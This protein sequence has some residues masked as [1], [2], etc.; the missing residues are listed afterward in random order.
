MMILVLNAD[1]TPLTLMPLKK[2]FKL[3]FKGK[4]EIIETKKSEIIKTVNRNFLR[5]SVVRLYRYVYFPYRKVTLSRFNV[6]KRDDY[7]CV[8]C[9]SKNQLTLDH[10]IPKSRGGANS[11]NNLVT[12]CMECNVIKGDRTPE[13]SG[14]K[15][16]HKPFTPNYLFFINKMHKIN[17]EWRPYLMMG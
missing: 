15:L 13:E 11:W 4:A 6:Y 9:G 12:C 1:Y 5:P 8:Y 14:M 10:V 3:I 16:S 17:E 7:K 2:A